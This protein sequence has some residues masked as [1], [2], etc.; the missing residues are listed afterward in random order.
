VRELVLLP[1]GREENIMLKIDVVAHYTH[2]DHGAL[3]DR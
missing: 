3:R 1:K 2:H